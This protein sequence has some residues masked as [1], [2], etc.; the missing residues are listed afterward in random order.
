MQNVDHGR[1]DGI[2][3]MP[4]ESFEYEVPSF[5]V[6]EWGYV[7]LLGSHKPIRIIPTR[8]SEQQENDPRRHRLWKRIKQRSMVEAYPDH[9]VYPVN[10]YNLGPALGDANKRFA[11]DSNSIGN[12]FT[13][14]L[15]S[16]NDIRKAL[17]KDIEHRAYGMESGCP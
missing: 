17:C 12:S 7:D 11:Q 6:G 10:D 15:G 8:L 3:F 13:G 5:L 1:G 4:A 9:M 14:R 2:V 16:G